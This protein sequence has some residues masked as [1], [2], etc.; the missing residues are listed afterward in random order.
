MSCKLNHLPAVFVAATALG[1]N[2][3]GAVQAGAGLPN[4]SPS[5]SVS[6]GSVKVFNADH[7]AAGASV[8]TVKCTGMGGAS[9]PDP[10]PAQAAPYT[11]AGFV[12]T[13]AINVPPLGANQ[14]FAHTIAFFASLS[15][16]PGKYAFTVCVDAGKA[17]RE[18]VER[19]NCK[20]FAKTVRAPVPGNLDL[21][22]RF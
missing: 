6:T 7:G 13:A 2:L 14:S 21:I 5:F 16:A 8:V 10:T 12:N 18:S 1:L 15:F 20:R 11:I 17:V 19:D 9:C 22:P 4:L 3:A